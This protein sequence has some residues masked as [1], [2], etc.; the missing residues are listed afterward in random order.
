M[1]ESP[2]NVADAVRE[3]K[4]GHE[5]M[6]QSQRQVRLYRRWLVVQLGRRL[7]APPD[8]YRYFANLLIASYIARELPQPIGDEKLRGLA[9][10]LLLL[11]F[12]VSREADDGPSSLFPA[13]TAAVPGV[14]P[15]KVKLTAMLREARPAMFGQ[16][17]SDCVFWEFIER[18]PED[19][20]MAFFRKVS[21]GARAYRLGRGDKTRCQRLPD[22]LR[23][24]EL[25]ARPAPVVGYDLELRAVRAGAEMSGVPLD[26]RLAYIF[27][28]C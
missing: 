28:A 13:L 20:K 14:S 4:I 25:L 2:W 7:P 5:T 11:A 18:V 17:L 22:T 10:R 23:P 1:A 9:E 3:C 24:I 16:Y 19:I 26:E 15:G 6:T 21:V 8:T 12:A 27:G